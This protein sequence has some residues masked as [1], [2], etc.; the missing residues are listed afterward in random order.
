MRASAPSKEAAMSKI[1]K[2]YLADCSVNGK[3]NNN[4]EVVRIGNK[5]VDVRLP[6]GSIIKRNV[7]KHEVDL[8]YISPVLGA[9]R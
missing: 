9:K 5:T 1:I 8:K 6:D 4:L 7:I 3:R 2:P